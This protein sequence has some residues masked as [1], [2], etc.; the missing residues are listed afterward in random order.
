MILEVISLGMLCAIVSLVAFV[1]ARLFTDQLT[2]GDY[3][4][5]SIIFFYFL[6]MLLFSYLIARRFNR[7]LYKFSVNTTLKGEVARND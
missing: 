2:M 6:L 4:G 7:R 1:I 3:M 5:F